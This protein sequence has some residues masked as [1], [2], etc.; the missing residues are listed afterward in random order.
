MSCAHAVRTVV[1]TTIIS[2]VCTMILLP[3]IARGGVTLS[4]SST[5]K[6]SFAA[7]LNNLSSSLLASQPVNP[8]PGSGSMPAP[9]SY[10]MSKTF[11][12]GTA[13]AT[14]KGSIGYVANSTTASFTLAAGSGVSQTDP[15]NLFTGDSSNKIEFDG[16]FNPTT[17][18]F[19]PPAT[20]YVSVTVGGNIGTG[21]HTQFIGQVQFLNAAGTA[22]FRSNVSFN[23]L[24][25]GTSTFSK[26]FV[27]SATLAPSSFPPGTPVRVKGFFQFL[28]SNLLGP[29]DIVPVQIECAAAPPDCHLVS[30]WQRKLEHVGELERTGRQPHRRPGGS[31]PSFP[32]SA[33]HRARFINIFSAPRTI[34][35]TTPITLN[36]LQVEARPRSR[37]AGSASTTSRSTPPA[38]TP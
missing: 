17:P 9:P 29:S 4:S 37:I 5:S 12:S 7:D 21:G 26:T 25:S 31:I 1:L 30:G 19:G 13:S 18:G 16:L 3:S 38:A 10:Q 28:A 14:A 23:Q 33:D 6:W 2:V 36:T 11:T 15:S 20:G 24:F 22:S 8:P 34:T 32:N 35:L 27:S